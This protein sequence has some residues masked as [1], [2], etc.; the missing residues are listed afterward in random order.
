MVVVVFGPSLSLICKTDA[1]TDF[2]FNSMG[3]NSIC[4]FRPLVA[5]KFVFSLGCVCIEREVFLPSLQGKYEDS[6]EIR[7]LFRWSTCP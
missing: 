3:S 7:C 1:D 2:D 6:E 5:N 4:A